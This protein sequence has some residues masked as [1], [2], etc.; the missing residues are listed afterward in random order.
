LYATVEEKEG[1]SITRQERL[2]DV[3]RTRL[4]EAAIEEFAEHGFD[5]ASYNRIIER[6]GLSKGTVYYYYDN[7]DSLLATMMDGIC[8]RFALLTEDIG[9]PDTKE[10]Y[11]ETIWKYHQRTIRFFSENPLIGRV[12]FRL[13]EDMC[14]RFDERLDN[15]HERASAFMNELLVRGQEIGAVRKD[16]P[17]ETIRRLMRAIGR[18][19]SIEVIRKRGGD[20]FRDEEASSRIK[21]FMDMMHDLS[22]RI[23]TP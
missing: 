1:I 3:K 8:E 15:A 16:M 20:V 7:K 6:S 22:K 23:L 17:L 13:K 2:D 11:W 19:L 12:M 21:K 10:E 18:A 14:T 4:M 5:S 9:M